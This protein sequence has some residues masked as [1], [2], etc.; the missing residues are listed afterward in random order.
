MLSPIL[1]P[2]LRLSRFSWSSWV[3]LLSLLPQCLHWDA[4]FPVEA[5]CLALYLENANSLSAIASKFPLNS[6]CLKRVLL[7]R[8]AS[9]TCPI[10]SKLVNVWDWMF[11]E[12]TEHC[13]YMLGLNPSAFGIL[14]LVLSSCFSEKCNLLV[15]GEVKTSSSMHRN[16][17]QWSMLLLHSLWFLRILFFD[18]FT[19]TIVWAK[20]QRNKHH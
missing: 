19:C 2:L 20:K 13:S 1:V 14:Y 5:S 15:G 3:P 16:R 10:K 12:F 6:K 7:K 8:S 4:F 17:R 9:L 11:L 18:Q